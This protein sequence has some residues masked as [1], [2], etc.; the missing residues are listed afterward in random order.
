MTQNAGPPTGADPSIPN[1]ARI[2]DYMLGGKDNYA[3]DRAAAR[4]VLEQ[5][6]HSRQACRQN[7]AFLGRVVTYL[8]GSQGITQFLDIGSGLPTRD[9]VHQIAQHHNGRA[10]TAYVDY[11]PVVAAHA[12]A[13]LERGT[14]G[15]TVVQADTRD[16]AAVLTGA[17]EL[18]DLT[19]PVAVLMFAIL[20]FLTDDDQPHDIVKALTRELAPGSALAVSHIT[21]DATPEEQALAAEKVYQQATAPAVPRTHA[22]ILRFFNGLQLAEPGLIDINHWP[23]RASTPAAPLTFY[24]GLARKPG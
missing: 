23:T 6:P 21:A 1:V 12:R 10:V 18:L 20:H 19:R 15:V 24:G 13:L 7:R 11:D 4:Q 3:A 22:E 14:P 8:A 5:I 16:P 9:N 2:Y 17:A